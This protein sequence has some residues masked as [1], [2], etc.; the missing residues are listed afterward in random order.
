MFELFRAKQA[1]KKHL[2]AP[3][4]ANERA[5][6]AKISKL[7]SEQINQ[8]FLNTTIDSDGLCH[9]AIRTSHESVESLISLCE[10][11]CPYNFHSMILSNQGGHIRSA[12]HSVLIYQPEM[13]GMVLDAIVRL[14]PDHLED[15]LLH[16]DQKNRNVFLSATLYNRTKSRWSEPL[17]TLLEKIHQHSPYI[18]KNLL[19]D[20]DSLGQTAWAVGM[21]SNCTLLDTIIIQYWQ[22]LPLY[23]QTISEKYPESLREHITRGSTLGNNALDTTKKFSPRAVRSLLN[24]IRDA[25]LDVAVKIDI[26]TTL[27]SET[28]CRRA[29]QLREDLIA[30]AFEAEAGPSSSISPHRDSLFQEPPPPYDTLNEDLFMNATP[31]SYGTLNTEDIMSSPPAYSP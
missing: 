1:L 17:T 16:P 8:L 2:V 10:I 25:D 30:G 28:R 4:E 21:R 24:G 23:L 7:S 5:L 20:H 9:S 11:Y 26:L 3:N 14:C 31:P 29:N 12:L 27:T 6:H 18:L 22:I 19:F 13:L 15:I